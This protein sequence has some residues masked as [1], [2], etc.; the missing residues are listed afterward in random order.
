VIWQKIKN[1]YHWLIAIAANICYGW[2]SRKLK[3][4]GV[5]GTD[6]KTTTVTLLAHILQQAGYQVDYVSTV[7]ATG[8]HT[9]TPDPWQLQRLLRRMTDRKIEYVVIEVTSHGL[10]QHRLAGIN[11]AAG[12]ITNVTHEH[13]DYHKT[14][15]NYLA[16]KAKL[17]RKS[18]IA[19]LNRDD[20]SYE[21]TEL[22]IKNKESRMITYAIKKTAD[23]TPKNFKF[24]TKLPGEYNQYNCLAAIAA[25]T[26]LGVEKDKIRRA[27]ASFEGVKGRMEA[28]NAGQSF[29]IFVDFAHTPNG[30][31]QALQ[32]ARAM[33]VK[34]GRL[35]V[36]SGAAGRRDASKRPLMGQALCELADQVILTS[37]DPRDEDP[38]KIIDQITRGCRQKAKVIREAD[39]HRAIANAL[40]LA[41]AGDVVL[42]CGKG[43]EQSMAVGKKDLPWDEA[44]IVSKTMRK[45][46]KSKS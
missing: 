1:I 40:S 46:L 8:L 22:R 28:I 41:R 39:R 16:A 23:F 32:T 17:F 44:A 38:D 5:T 4:I 43:H 2:P 45:I 37:E 21:K 3:V 7:K 25:A 36:L 42:F 9:T 15:E 11:F 18:R 29:K 12:V 30:L 20:Q 10:D 6:G 35:I 34:R 33:K 13:L 19:I 26:A 24:K 14:Y 27:V 31:R